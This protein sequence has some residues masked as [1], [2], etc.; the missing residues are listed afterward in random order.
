MKTQEEIAKV[1][2]NIFTSIKRKIG[3]PVCRDGIVDYESYIQTDPR[4]LFIQ[5][6]PKERIIL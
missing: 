3:A 6:Y 1:E 4:I 2:K 5:K